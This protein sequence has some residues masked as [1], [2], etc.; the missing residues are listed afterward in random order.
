MDENPVPPKYVPIGSNVDAICTHDGSGVSC[1]INENKL[2]DPKNKL[3]KA[4]LSIVNNITSKLTLVAIP[5]CNENGCVPT[6]N[7]VC[8]FNSNFSILKTRT[9]YLTGC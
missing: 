9:I 3:L 7:I 8:K 1:S 4:N 6:L 5:H 2:D